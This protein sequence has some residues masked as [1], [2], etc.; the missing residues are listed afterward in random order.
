MLH[1]TFVRH[2]HVYLCYHNFKFKFFSANK[3]RVWRQEGNPPTLPHLKSIISI[4]SVSLITP[5]VAPTDT[6]G[7][8]IN[9]HHNC[10]I[11]LLAPRRARMLV[12]KLKIVLTAYPESQYNACCRS[13]WYSSIMAVMILCTSSP[14][15]R[16]SRY[17]CISFKVKM[18][19]RVQVPFCQR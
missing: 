11:Y 5:S 8:S 3:S 13:R 15:E 4:V 2:V 18:R 17:E 12:K 1:R 6:S 14:R 19:G 7:S 9:V 16:S 10:S